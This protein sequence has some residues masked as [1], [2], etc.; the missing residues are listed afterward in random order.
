MTAR[1]WRFGANVLLL[2][3]LGLNAGLLCYVRYTAVAPGSQ[4]QFPSLTASIGSRSRAEPVDERSRAKAECALAADFYHRARDIAAARKGY[5]LAASIDPAYPPPHWNLAVLAEAEERWADAIAHFERFLSLLPPGSDLAERAQN[6]VAHV[7]SLAEGDS[8]PVARTA[9]RYGEAIARAR[10]ALESGEIARGVEECE[11][12]TRIDEQRYEAFALGAIAL[13]RAQAPA[14]AL[15]FLRLARERAPGAVRGDLDAAI[16]KCSQDAEAMTAEAEAA[17]AVRSGDTATAARAYAK[18]FELRPTR[19]D[20]GLQAATALALMDRLV[21]ARA[22]LS[23]LAESHDVNTV[24]LATRRLAQLEELELLRATAARDAAW[25]SFEFRRGDVPE[26][27][28]ATA[29]ANIESFIQEGGA[30]P[31][32]LDQARARLE[33]VRLL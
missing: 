20:L 18:A 28:L 32:I 3:S 16:A 22:V 33:E 15:E 23:K 12:A 5:E 26:R 10:V 24:A 25:I 17:A 27:H 13:A 11:A 9:R 31:A 19:D 2:I 1:S 30:S 14:R 8:D 21:D 4:A 29:V 7:R 6:R